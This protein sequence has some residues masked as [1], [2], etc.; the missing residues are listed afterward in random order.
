MRGDDKTFCLIKTLDIMEIHNIILISAIFFLALVSVFLL[1][2]TKKKYFLL[3][4]IWGLVSIVSV[5]FFE[6]I[7]IIFTMSAQA[8]VLA[9]IVICIVYDKLIKSKAERTLQTEKADSNNVNT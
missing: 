7:D 4:T 2:K 1:C 3:I 9:L 5:I 6:T 8:A